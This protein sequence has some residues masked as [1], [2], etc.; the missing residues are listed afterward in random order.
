MMPDRKLFTNPASKST[1]ARYDLNAFTRRSISCNVSAGVVSSSPPLLSLFYKQQSKH[2]C[3]PV[4]VKRASCV[5]MSLLEH[6]CTTALKDSF[7]FLE[8]KGIRR[9]TPLE[10]PQLYSIPSPANS[11]WNFGVIITDTPSSW[12]SYVLERVLSILQQSPGSWP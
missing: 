2:I 7:P 4:P 5:R 11:A 3:M 8:A 1:A 10:I 12:P 6:S 9:Y